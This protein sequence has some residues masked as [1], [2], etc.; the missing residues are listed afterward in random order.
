[1]SERQ[2]KIVKKERKKEKKKAKKSKTTE[3]KHAKLA[4]QYKR[5]AKESRKRDIAKIILQKRQDTFLNVSCLTNKEKAASFLQ[6]HT[7]NT[8]STDHNTL[9]RV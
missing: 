7:A 8:A 1:M 5:M 2:K 4:S 3:Q 9:M 6:T